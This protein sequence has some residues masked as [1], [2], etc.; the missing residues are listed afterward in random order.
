MDKFHIKNKLKEKEGNI[1]A[2]IIVTAIIIA[3]I[4]GMGVAFGNS[5]KGAI[6]KGVSET[7]HGFEHYVDET[8]R[9]PVPDAGK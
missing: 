8:S 3:A 4:V 7:N 1:G 9:G 2:Y 6:V 5:T